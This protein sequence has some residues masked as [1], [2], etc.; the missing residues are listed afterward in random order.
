SCREKKWK[1]SSHKTT[2]RSSRRPRQILRGRAIAGELTVVA[3]AVLVV[4]PAVSVTSPA[5]VT[6]AET[7]MAKANADVLVNAIPR[8]PEAFQAPGI[9]SDNA[10]L[11][12][13]IAVFRYQNL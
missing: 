13:R 2:C 5:G 9:T 12:L 3:M 7:R 8:A 6:V 10:E 11:R 1:A 4:S